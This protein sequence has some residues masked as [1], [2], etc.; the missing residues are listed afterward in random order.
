MHQPVRIGIAGASGMMGRNRMLH[1]SSDE[2]CI[3]AA[4]AARDAQRLREALDCADVRTGSDPAELYAADDLDAVAICVPN[5]LHYEHTKAALCAGKHVLCEYPITNSLEQYDELVALA[6][7]NGLTLHHSLTT[8][9]ESLH[10]TM[11]QA[12]ATLGEPR[13]AYYR[14][15]GTSSW[16]VRP[17]LRGDMYCALHI[18]FMDQFADF[19]GTPEACIAHGIERD[20]KV[21][22]VVMMQWPGGL[23]GTVEFCMG[24]GDRPG[25]MGT[26]VTTDGWCG[27]SAEDG[28]IVTVEK[29]GQTTR[30]IPPPDTSQADDA[31]S[32]IDEITGA[33][34]P[35]RT[36][37]DSRETLAMCLSCR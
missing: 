27:F 31:R 3:V 30:S 11:K 25:Y 7:S 8:R 33:G 32:F 9:H 19:F 23:V 20:A 15:Y 35:Q 24:F 36:L 26:V 12:L 4:A 18:H 17:E 2:R 21:S 14:Y 29:G 16:Y 22:A 34:G 13:A 37:E 10:L 1:F 28:I 5:T 6:Q